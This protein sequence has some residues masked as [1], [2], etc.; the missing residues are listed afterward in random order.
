MTGLG[1]GTWH[2]PHQP[3]SRESCTRQHRERGGGLRQHS[4]KVPRLYRSAVLYTVMT[5][6]PSATV[7]ITKTSSPSR[8]GA[9]PSSAREAPAIRL[10]SSGTTIPAAILITMSSIVYG[11]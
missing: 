1:P 5:T 3:P 10:T 8:S 11:Q 2:P 4:G 7:E 9:P 6:A